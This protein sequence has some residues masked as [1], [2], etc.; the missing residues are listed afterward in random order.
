M[1]DALCRRY[2]YAGEY[3]EWEQE[4]G[5]PEVVETPVKAL[6]RRQSRA[7]EMGAPPPVKNIPPSVMNAIVRGHTVIVLWST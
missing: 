7:H 2:C 6:M 3:G 1:R 5:A 4:T